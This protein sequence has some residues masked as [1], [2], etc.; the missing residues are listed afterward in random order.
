MNSK[1]IGSFFQTKAWKKTTL[2]Y[3]RETKD[4]L[5]KEIMRGVEELAGVNEN[6]I[7]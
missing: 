5:N 3:M 4:K 7:L 6:Y 2:P 1:E